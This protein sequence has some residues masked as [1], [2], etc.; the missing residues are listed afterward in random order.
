M[1]NTDGAWPRSRGRGR[2]RGSGGGLGAALPTPLEQNGEES[3]NSKSQLGL[4]GR[5]EGTF[6]MEGDKPLTTTCLIR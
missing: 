3:T 6:V 1:P 2:G 5:Y 4:L